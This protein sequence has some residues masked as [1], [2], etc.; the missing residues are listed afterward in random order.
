MNKNKKEKNTLILIIY[1]YGVYSHACAEDL[2]T[3]HTFSFIGVLIFQSSLG[4]HWG[5]LGYHLVS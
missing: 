2:L 5:S 1:M 4:Y 3:M